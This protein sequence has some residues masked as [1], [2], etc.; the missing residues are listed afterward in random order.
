MDRIYY[1]GAEFIPAKDIIAVNKNGEIYRMFRAINSA[2]VDGY[3]GR[4]LLIVNEENEPLEYISSGSGT[5]YGEYRVL[6]VETLKEHY[7]IY[8]KIIS[9]VLLKK[10][11]D[12][13]ENLEKQNELLLEYSFSKSKD[14]N[15]ISIEA[16]KNIRDLITEYNK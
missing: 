8:Q 3:I 12:S 2:L 14:N 10:I 9:N 1:Q 16:Y 13:I 7:K 5:F 6:D 15:S 11:N 4:D